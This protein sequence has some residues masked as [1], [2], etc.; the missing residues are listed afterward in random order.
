MKE[1][2]EYINNPDNDLVNFNL[3]SFYEKQQ[4]YSPASTFYLRAAEKTNS[5]DLRYE[6][7]IRV[8]LCFNA[9]GSRFY[10]CE[11]LLKQAI[12]LCPQKPEAYFFLTQLYETKSD[13]VNIYMYSNIALQVCDF[14][15]NFIQPVD[16]PG[17]YAFLFQKAASAWW[18]GKPFESRQI[19]RSLLEE[20][21]DKLNN[22]Y[23][24]LLE[25]N[26]SKIGLLPESDAVKPYTKD[27]LNKLKY[28]FDN[29]EIIDKNFSQAYQDMFVLTALNGKKC[30]TYLEIGASDPFKNNNT[31]LLETKFDWTGI[32]IEY[33]E[34]M[35]NRY[36]DSRKNTVLLMD[37]LLIDY[38]RLLG[39]YFPH[40]KQIDYLQLDIDPPQNT[41]EV[42]LSIP[43]SKYSFS[44][45]TYEHDYYIDTTKSY[46]DKSRQYLSS[47]GYKLIAPN[48]SPNDNS[49]FED[50]WI[51]PNLV[52]ENIWTESCS[53]TINPIEKLFLNYQ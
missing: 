24:K 8:F 38:G 21:T 1:L 36:K 5:L 31:A 3:G 51:N 11:T 48:V 46:R 52:C 43:F 23:K 27:K 13:W 26:I 32:G 42:L 2:Y 16:F 33:D 49:P 10:T 37:A 29:I 41:Y 17:S 40:T 12:S 4:H 18:V 28:R 53:N 34:Q 50:W 47:L 14:S 9:L 7:L 44:V 25:S 22:S 15:S 39:K 30:G 35:V 6:V 19:L 20:Y 45:I